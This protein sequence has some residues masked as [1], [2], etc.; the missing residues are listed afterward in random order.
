MKT[1]SISTKQTETGF[2]VFVD[3]KGYAATYPA[4]VWTRLPDTLKTLL[5]ETTAFIFT[6]H[7][8]ILRKVRLLYA[9]PSPPTASFF[10]HGLV[11]SLLEPSVYVKDK[12]A[13]LKKVFNSFSVAQFTGFP[14]LYPRNVYKTTPNSAIIP[15][16]FGKDSLLT[17]AI[18]KELGLTCELFFF[19]EPC[20]P[21]E[22]NSRISLRS[23][24]FKKTGQDVH[25]IPYEIG[26][27]RQDGGEMWGWDL[28]L[29]QYLT[30]L[31][32]Y[33]FVHGTKY[34]LLSNEQNNNSLE[35]DTQ[36]LIATGRFEQSN[37]WTLH[38][39]N[40][41]HEFS[42]PAV[43][44]S[45]ITPVYE[46]IT[47]YVLHH[48]YAYLAPYHMSCCGDSKKAVTKG[49]CGE[50]FACA[51]IYLFLI[52]FGIDPK[53]VG[54]HTD[55]FQESKKEHF[56]IFDQKYR[57]DETLLLKDHGETLL[58]F[59]IASRRGSKG[60]MV[61]LFAS[62]F[63]TTVQKELKNLMEKY[64][65]MSDLSTLPAEFREKITRLYTQELRSL[66]TS[67]KQYL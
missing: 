11:F 32:P 37:Q 3:R 6:Y 53:K 40:I 48:R 63:V 55:M 52:S 16:T 10:F 46:Y 65:R 60:P 54:I 14:S 24:F 57:T 38:V 25:I 35:I 45:L 34:F 9:F 31:I 26:A 27:L 51:R 13:S 17:Y 58:A 18:A 41:L 66:Q 50:C 21:Y 47:T 30:Y 23:A 22:R 67:L 62:Q 1:L 49:W 59:Y 42:S 56:G 7:L 20:S 5:A 28:L 4:G 61:E 39:N 44:T 43:A 2:T 15:F 64:L 8:G 36:G 33:M 19:D 12:V 29:F